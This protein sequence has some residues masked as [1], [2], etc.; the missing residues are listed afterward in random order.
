MEDE[1]GVFFGPNIIIIIILGKKNLIAVRARRGQTTK[2]LNNCPRSIIRLSL[3][4][5]ANI[6]L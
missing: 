4:T 6:L 1:Y 2:A 5:S 3:L